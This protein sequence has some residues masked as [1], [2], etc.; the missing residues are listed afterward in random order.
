VIYPVVLVTD[1]LCYSATG[2]F[3]VGFQDPQIGKICGVN[4]NTGA[5]AINFNFCRKYLIGK[6]S[7]EDLGYDEDEIGRFDVGWW[8]ESLQ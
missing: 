6:E 3:A 4:A 8:R 5:R 1:A 7:D 2:Y